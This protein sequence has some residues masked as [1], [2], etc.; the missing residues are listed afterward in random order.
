MTGGSNDRRRRAG[1]CPPYL[2]DGTS[3]LHSPP[4]S[5]SSR[6]NA[7][8]G[9]RNRKSS[10]RNGFA[11]SRNRKSSR[12]RPL[13]QSRSSTLPVHSIISIPSSTSNESRQPQ[14][15]GWLIANMGHMGRIGQGRLHLSG[16]LSRHRIRRMCSM[17]PIS[18]CSAHAIAR[19][20]APSPAIGRGRRAP[21][22]T[23]A[24]RRG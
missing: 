2:A 24:R 3:A 4:A 20:G 14:C 9:S 18:S 7:F 23:R 13:T 1:D 8:A 10:R 5:S 12:N 22:A 19:R 11:G 16:A 17:R 6:E 21:P 15:P